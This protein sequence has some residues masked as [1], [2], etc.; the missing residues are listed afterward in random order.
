MSIPR[1]IFLDIKHSTSDK[2]C[3]K[4][5]A[6]FRYIDQA[7]HMGRLVRACK[8]GCGSLLTVLNPFQIYFY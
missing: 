2:A 4:I 8:S 3:L 7:A 5:E 1:P 6:N